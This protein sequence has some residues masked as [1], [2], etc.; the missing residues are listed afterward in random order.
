M[1]NVWCPH[2]SRCL[3]RAI[4]SGAD[5][6]TCHGCQWEQDHSGIPKGTAEI[7]EDARGCTALLISVF[8]RVKIQEALNRVGYS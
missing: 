8:Q 3:D 4:E 1:R 6:F 5:G 7:Y 2:Y